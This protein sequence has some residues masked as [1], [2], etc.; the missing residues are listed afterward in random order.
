LL[1]FLSSEAEM[2]HSEYEPSNVSEPIQDIPN[3]DL[4]S[5]EQYEKGELAFQND[6]R[7]LC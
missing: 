3:N 5:D 7:S 4:L 2:T 1:E 6:G